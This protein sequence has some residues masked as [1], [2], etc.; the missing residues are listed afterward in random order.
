MYDII[1]KENDWVYFLLGLF[2]IYW[3]QKDTQRF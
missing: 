1:I 2:Y 3:T